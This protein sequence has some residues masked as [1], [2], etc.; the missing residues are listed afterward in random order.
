MMTR[1][2]AGICA[3][4]LFLGAGACAPKDSFVIEGQVEGLA[5]GTVMTLKLGV[6]HKDEKP[7]LEAVV[8]GGK[9]AFT[10]SVESPRL[11]NIG[12]QGAWGVLPVVVENGNRVKITGKVDYQGEGDQRIANF[13][14]VKVT[15][16]PLQEEYEGKMAYKDELAKQYQA[17]HERNA[18]ISKQISDAR[19]AGD[20]ALMDSLVE[21]EAYAVFK[22]EEKEFFNSVEEQTKNVVMSNK[23]TWW[24][25]L[26]MLANMD[27]FTEEQK[28][29]FA[30]F[31]PEAQKSFY[32]QIVYNELYPAASEG[33]PAPAFTVQDGNGASFNLQQLMAGKKYLLLDFWASWCGPCRKEIP[34]LKA[35]YE[36]FASKGL[37]IV[38]ISIDKDAAAWQ[39][40]L[41]EEQLPWRNFRDETGVADAYSVSAIPAIFLVDGSGTIIATGLRGTALQEKLETLLP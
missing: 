38:S 24:G 1:I 7:L 28:A 33:N 36:K 8:S 16:S 26:M 11:F 2:Y 31:S 39:K 30:E 37:E 6:T 13:T 35:V 9:F 40:A 21:T 17:Y 22:K 34:N 15:G 23:D 19:G 29:W 41:E 27:W 25:P 4:L 18:E 32:G 12:Q 5:D 20:K 14:E 10:Y 3:L